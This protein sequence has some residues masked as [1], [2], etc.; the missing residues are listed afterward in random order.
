MT[1]HKGRIL[2]AEALDYSNK[3]LILYFGQRVEGLKERMGL[4]LVTLDYP[5]TRA[6]CR[7]CPPE[8]VSRLEVPCRFA[9]IVGIGKDLL[10]VP[11]L[12]ATNCSASLRR[13]NAVSSSAA[14]SNSCRRA[15]AS[16]RAHMFVFQSCQLP[17]PPSLAVWE[18]PRHRD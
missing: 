12:G 8:S 10:S 11:P 6:Q 9:N 7:D 13:Y 14:R 5:A 16:L 17:S 15:C 2:L 1:G 4:S 18:W 3:L